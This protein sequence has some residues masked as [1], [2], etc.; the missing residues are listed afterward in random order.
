MAENSSVDKDEIVS[1]TLAKIYI[2]QGLY[3]KSLKIYKKLILEYPE[4]SSYFAAQIENL[5]NKL[6]K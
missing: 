3:E 5:E 6:R 2:T 1:E 4:K